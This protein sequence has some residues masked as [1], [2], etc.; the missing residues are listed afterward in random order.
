MDARRESPL[1]VLIGRAGRANRIGFAADSSRQLALERESPRARAG[2]KDF[3][4]SVGRFCQNR[5]R[6]AEANR[7]QRRRA[8]ARRAD[9]SEV[10]LHLDEHRIRVLISR[11]AAT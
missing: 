9:F 5:Q 1:F 8:C 7:L 3:S 4:A 10:G 2:C 6:F 11:R